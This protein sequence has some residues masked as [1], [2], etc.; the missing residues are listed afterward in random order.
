M[1]TIK[2]KGKSIFKKWWFWLIIVVIIIA[3]ATG[4]GQKSEKVGTSSSSSSQTQ[5]SQITIQDSYAIND[6]VKVSDF[7]F[8]VLSAKNYI[9]S[10]QSIKP[11][12]GYK[13]I[14]VELYIENKGI[15]KETVSTIL[16]FYLKDSDG[17][18]ATQSFM[19]DDKSIDGELLKGDKIK[20]TITYEVPINSSGLKLYYNPS[21][22][23]GKSIVVNLSI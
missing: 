6:I 20:G 7:E 10:N 14:K 9:S 13:F 8:S 16:N 21:F 2:K 12:E 23:T 17:Q 5:Q 22:I 1:R 18:K 15:N 11:K 3:I 19:G 4:S